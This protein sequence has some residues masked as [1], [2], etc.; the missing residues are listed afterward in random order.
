MKLRNL[1]Q[2]SDPAP[3]QRAADP[4]W[5]A[6]GGYNVTGRQI[7]NH[8][9]A[10][11][12]ATVLAC[13]GAVSTAIASL[14]VW[15]YRADGDARRVNPAHPMARLVRRGPN[16]HQSWPAFLEWFLASAL[17]RGNALAELVTD[18]RGRVIELRPIPWE[19]VSVQL[20]PSGRLAY[21]VVAINGLYGGTGRVRRLLQ[22]EV[23][24]LRDRSED[25]LV[26]VS[27]L[28][29]AASTIAAGLS[30]QEFANSMYANGINPSGALEV[31]GFLSQ[32]AYDH[33]V[34][35]F[36]ESFSGTRNAAKGLVLDQGVK[37]KQISVSPEDAE[38]LASRRFTT[39]EL[40]RIFQVPPPLVGIWDHST[41]TNS[42][43]A[44]KWF[45]QHTLQPWIRKIECEFQ[46][47]CSPRPAGQP[48]RWK[49][50]F[51][52]S[53]AATTPPAGRAT[54]SPFKTA[55]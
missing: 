37:W 36:R 50:T 45:A 31:D 24:H 17:L 30:V 10:E 55:S 44:G 16:E 39:E 21:D 35:S 34:K 13:V 18:N 42:E 51:P 47:P 2:R 23:I 14:P 52:A 25:G 7:V 3:E 5:A 15:I 22:G 8:R 38:M 32:E 40:A 54:P 12:L 28:R 48:T 49:S 11:G 4:S 29:R 1:F 20:L 41:F 43:T 9:T 27:R 26:G 33:L 53:C 19:N 6:V 46:R